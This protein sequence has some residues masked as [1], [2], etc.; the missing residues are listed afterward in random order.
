MKNVHEG[1]V[2]P[3][4]QDTEVSAQNR[5]SP[6]ANGF[7][8]HAGRRSNRL[9]VLVGTYSRNRLDSSVGQRAEDVT[10][11]CTA[12]V[13]LSPFRT[14]RLWTALGVCSRESSSVRLRGGCK[15]CKQ[16]Q[17]SSE[18]MS[19]AC[20]PLVLGRVFV[21]RILISCLVKSEINPSDSLTNPGLQNSF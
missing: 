21:G 14:R 6:N 5:S 20:H 17:R 15:S 11:V 12:A 7:Q 1:L 9:R 10:D 13:Q 19:Q 16:L 18:E 2:P 4:T 8:I 3:V